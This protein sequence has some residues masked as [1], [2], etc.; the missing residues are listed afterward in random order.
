MPKRK[1]ACGLDD[2]LR[3]AALLPA[4]AARCGRPGSRQD[5]CEELSSQGSSCVRRG[6]AGAPARRSGSGNAI[7]DE[8]GSSCSSIL[9]VWRAPRGRPRDDAMFA[10]LARL[11]ADYDEAFRSPRRPGARGPVQLYPF[12]H[13]AMFGRLARGLRRAIA[14]RLTMRNRSAAR[15][16]PS[17]THDRR[18]TTRRSRAQARPTD[19]SVASTQGAAVPIDSRAHRTRTR[20]SARAPLRGSFAIVR[21]ESTAADSA[22]WYP[23]Q[24]RGRRDPNHGLIVGSST[25]ATRRT[26]AAKMMARRSRGRGRARVDIATITRSR[27]LRTTDRAP[28]RRLYIRARKERRPEGG[29]GRMVPQTGKDAKPI[30]N[31]DVIVSSRTTRQRTILVAS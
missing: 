27:R 6:A 26:Q 30:S 13:V 19:A 28:T 9:R 29:R 24:A 20:A 16:E 17:P 31:S 15:R 23:A 21:G 11:F 18:E 12:V 22:E 4:V 14:T 2:V 5:E 8:R 3:R 1:R 10:V 25:W 7:H